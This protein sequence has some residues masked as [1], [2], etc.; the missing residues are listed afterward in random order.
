MFENKKLPE[1]I[2]G[3]EKPFF[4]KFKIKNRFN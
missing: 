3:G 4:E 1:M 2:E